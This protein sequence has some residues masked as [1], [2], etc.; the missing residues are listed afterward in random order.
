MDAL[1]DVRVDGERL[2]ALRDTLRTPNRFEMRAETKYREVFAAAIAF[3]ALDFKELRI[4][5]VHPDGTTRESPDLLVSSDRG[6]LDVEVVRVD[7]TSATRAHLFQVQ[8]RFAAILTDDP[9]L[10]PDKLTTFTVDYERT[11]AL[12]GT[13]LQQLGDELCEFFQRKRW[14][15]LSTGTHASVFPADSVASRIGLVVRVASPL[16]AAPL[17]FAQADGM[18]PYP[19]ILSTIRAKREI[20]YVR[21][22]PLWLAVEIAD[23]RG[24]FTEAIFALRDTAPEIAPFDN[25]V[26]Y[27]ALTLTK[28]VL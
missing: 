28:V 25:V 3:T 22:H 12:T 7:E 27:D 26:A 19:L 6:I 17:T 4:S 11:R 8:A 16:Y 2:L 20:E 24:P 1:R 21:T 15:F 13:E 18:T 9:T 10:K 5:T 14:Q 23:P